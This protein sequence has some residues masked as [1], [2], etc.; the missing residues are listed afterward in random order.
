[1]L[2]INFKQKS[3]CKLGRGIPLPCLEERNNNNNLSYQAR[4]AP[5]ERAWRHYRVL[6]V[7]IRGCTFLQRQHCRPRLGEKTKQSRYRNSVRE[8]YSESVVVGFRDQHHLLQCHRRRKDRMSQLARRQ[9]HRISSIPV[10]MTGDAGKWRCA[11]CAIQL[12]P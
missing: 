5:G 4:C 3:S 6:F 12:R 8:H 2:I 1:M 10:G 7:L 9:G 11:R